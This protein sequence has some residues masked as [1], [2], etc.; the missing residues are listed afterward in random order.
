MVLL[1]A[2][3]VPAVPTARTTPTQVQSSGRILLA[4]VVDTSGKTQV[5]FGVDDFLIR[6]GGDEREVLD[7]HVADYPMVMLIDDGPQAND[8][9]PIKSAIA[10]FIARIGERPVA[11]GTLSRPTEFVASLD[12]SREEV[13]ERLANMPGTGS[14]A[15]TLPA[16]AH[17]A[18][19]LQDTGSPFSAIIVVTGRAIDARVPV[20]GDLL[21]TIT[22]SGATVHVVESQASQLGVT[23]AIGAEPVPDL[24][25]VLADQ[26]HGQYTT[27][28]TSASYGTALDRLADKLSAE[29]MIQYLVP[30]NEVGGDVQVGVRRP[31]SRVVGLGV[32]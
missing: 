4:S 3:A 32:K 1:L 31:G 5:D 9:R 25:R 2:L 28:F 20:E 21:P 18:R 19:A 14:D 7:V 30:P 17:A 27:I 23:D 6:E 26:T 13:L 24:L 29:L 12:D 11:I 8:L 16:V 15:S 10:R 22:E